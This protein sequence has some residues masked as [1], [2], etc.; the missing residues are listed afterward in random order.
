MR[1]RAFQNCNGKNRNAGNKS[2]ESLTPVSDITL[3]ETNS[4]RLILLYNHA[5]HPT[6]TR[7]SKSWNLS[8]DRIRVPWNVG[9]ADDQLIAIDLNIQYSNRRETGLL[10]IERRVGIPRLTPDVEDD[11]TDFAYRERRRAQQRSDFIFTRIRRT[12]TFT[13]QSDKSVSH[14]RLSYTRRAE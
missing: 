5:S 7:A 12:A 10:V 4:G 11:S 9:L 3:S 8:K 14:T 2:Y 6:S 1:Y 13:F